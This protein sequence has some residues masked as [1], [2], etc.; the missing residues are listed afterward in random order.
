MREGNGG[1]E[2]R[3]GVL[4]EIENSKVG[5]RISILDGKFIEFV[6]TQVQFH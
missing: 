1:G 4:R 2:R 6:I 3:K 5:E